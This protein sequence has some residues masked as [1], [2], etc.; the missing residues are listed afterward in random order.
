MAT[1]SCSAPAPSMLVSPPPPLPSLPTPSSLSRQRSHREVNESTRRSHHN[2]ALFAPPP[3]PPPPL[4]HLPGLNFPPRDET[5]TELSSE[6][7]NNEAGNRLRSASLCV[8][9]CSVSSVVNSQSAGVE[10]RWAPPHSIRTG[11][12]AGLRVPSWSQAN[13][14]LNER[15]PGSRLTEDLTRLLPEYNI[16]GWWVGELNGALGIVPK[17]FLH[18]AYIL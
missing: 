18:P 7:Q 9:E 10:R 16:H 5:H 15:P 1:G 4:E 11:R 3:T 14:C 17:D 8:F 6:S 12:T 2:T 13:T